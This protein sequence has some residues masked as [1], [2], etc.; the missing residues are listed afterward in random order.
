MYHARLMVCSDRMVP[1]WARTLQ[2]EL[3]T[4]QEDNSSPRTESKEQTKSE[5]NGGET[6]NTSPPQ[7]KGKKRKLYCLCRKPYKRSEG[8]MVRCD[9]CKD[10]FHF[11]CVGQTE[12]SVRDINIYTCPGGEP[13]GGPVHV[14]V[15]GRYVSML[16]SSYIVFSLHFRSC[17][18]CRVKPLIL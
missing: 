15:L 14:W 7:K 3:L 16:Y 8:G 10:W 5:G 12:E 6:E 2:Q 9:Q 1:K 17:F 18:V 4:Q 13:V 11:F